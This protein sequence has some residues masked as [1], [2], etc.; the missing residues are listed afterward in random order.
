M[1]GIKE[2]LEQMARGFVEKVAS[3]AKVGSVLQ[4]C[5]L[6]AKSGSYT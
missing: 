4:K 6:H 5:H 3:V 2:E 1:N